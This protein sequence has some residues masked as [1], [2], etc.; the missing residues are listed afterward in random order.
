MKGKR[1]KIKRERKGLITIIVFNIRI[2]F[3]ISN[4]KIYLINLVPN[5]YLF[6]HFSHYFFGGHFHLQPLKINQIR[7][8][9]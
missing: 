6:F 8:K 2:Y 1:K 7:M 9:N 4:N 5:V 3:T